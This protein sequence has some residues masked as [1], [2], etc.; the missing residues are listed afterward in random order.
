MS[1][2][3]LHKF[4]K[5]AIYVKRNIFVNYANGYNDSFSAIFE[6]TEILEISLLCVILYIMEYE[7]KVRLSEIEK[8]LDKVLPEAINDDWKN[9]SFGNFKISPQERDFLNIVRPA[10]DLMRRGG[11]RWRPLLAVLSCELAGG[12]MRNVYPLTPLVELCHTASLI[13]DD[14]EDGSETRRG[15]QAIHIKYGIDTAIN[16]GSWLYFHA[17]QVIDT[18]DTSAETK[19]LLHKLYLLNLRRLHL[20]QSMDISW[21]SVPD[22]IPTKEEYLAMIELKTGS[23]SKLAGEL[24]FAAAGK[25]EN[26]ING[27]GCLMMEAGIAFQILDDVKN[28]TAGIAGKK[29][30]D[31]IV[32]GKK[33]L[34]VIFCTEKD[35][36]SRKKLSELF[37]RA[38][39]E[40]IE[41]SAVEESISVILNS[42][43]AELSK[44]YAKDI[45]EASIIKLQ[46]KYGRNKAADLIAELF[47]SICGV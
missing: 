27:Y 2:F 4:S 35:P 11:K 33:S 15:G 7:F 31:D 43:A 29:R 28:I 6:C 12:E 1:K 16:S 40:G 21:H 25:G 47:L 18:Y 36:S 37:A 39:K 26:E 9:A 13:H 44:Q 5:A 30:G 17:M 32:E 10:A 34:P 8:T 22:Y 20:G 41:S 42:G 38:A 19:N 45:V 24:G 23:L 3:F 46:K 14:I